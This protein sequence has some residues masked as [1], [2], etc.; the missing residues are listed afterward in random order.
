MVMVFFPFSTMATVA[1]VVSREVFPVLPVTLPW[2]AKPHLLLV[3]SR[4]IPTLPE[5]PPAF[6]RQTIISNLQSML[7]YLN[8][9]CTLP[10]H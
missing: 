6:F 2:P 7:T 8:A 10:L 9:L 5:K 1:M 3:S 4:Y